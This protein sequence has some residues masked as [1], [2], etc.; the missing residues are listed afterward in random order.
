MILKKIVDNKT[1]W[2]TIKPLFSSNNKIT[3]I[4]NEDILSEEDV[5]SETMNH[6]FSNIIG[7]SNMS[8]ISDDPVIKS[9]EKFKNHPSIQAINRNGPYDT[10]SFSKVNHEEIVKEIKNVGTSK[11]SQVSDIPTK[12]IKTNCDIFSNFIHPS[13]NETIEKSEFPRA[14]KLADVTPIFKKG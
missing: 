14:L 5:I 9:V 7:N 2:K 11:A 10:F 12:I 6:L 8:E 1:F 4:E 13:Y 3:L